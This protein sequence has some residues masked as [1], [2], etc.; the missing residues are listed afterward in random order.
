[1]EAPTLAL[2]LALDRYGIF[3][4]KRQRE[5]PPAPPLLQLY[6]VFKRRTS[7]TLSYEHKN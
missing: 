1:M 3:E 7:Q 5:L 2:A 6:I 4:L